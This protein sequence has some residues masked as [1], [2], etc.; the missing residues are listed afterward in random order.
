VLIDEAKFPSQLV[1]ALEVARGIAQGRVILL[2]GGSSRTS[3]D[4]LRRKGLIAALAADYTVIT[5]Q[6]PRLTNPAT[7]IAEI[8]LGSR[9]AGG[10]EGETF[11]CV[12]DRGEAIRH[13]LAAA[14]PGDCVVLAGMGAEREFDI[15]GESRSWDE[16]AIAH[17]ALIDLGYRP[18]NTE[19]AAG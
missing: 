19:P 15:G 8:A 10:R 11:A 9:L 16:A 12:V 2:V 14:G 17:T 6:D 4:Q 13:A 3:H 18:A 1:H 7:L 5:S